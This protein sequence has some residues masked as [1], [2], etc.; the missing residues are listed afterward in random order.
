MDVFG[1]TCSN[2][3]MS[4]ELLQYLPLLHPPSIEWSELCGA[5]RK[6]T[7]SGESDPPP[8]PC[9]LGLGSSVSPCSHDEEVRTSRLEP[10]STTDGRV[11][12][13]HAGFT[14]EKQRRV[15]PTVTAVPK[16]NDICLTVK[17]DANLSESL[18]QTL[19]NTLTHFPLE[20]VEKAK[21][22]FSS[23]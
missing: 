10:L 13:L 22:S 21:P 17:L 7:V 9:G 1:Q 4:P 12:V 19:A 18:E 16:Q 23:R 5:P 2:R 14:V 6:S 3:V 15:I 11:T 20:C 8:A